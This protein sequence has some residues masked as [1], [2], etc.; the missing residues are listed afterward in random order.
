[1][2][3]SATAQKFRHTSVPRQ[4]GE[5]ARLKVVQGPDAGAIYVV[6]G[7]RATIGRGEDCDVVVSDLKASRS[8]AELNLAGNQWSLKDL[9]SA[10]GVVLNGKS[11][12]AGALKANDVFVV[13]ETTLICVSPGLRGAPNVNA[14]A[15]PRPA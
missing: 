6:N 13:G 11:M 1:M 5:R 10:N 8:H 9:G 14:V 12:R 4:A 3:Q 7:T 2:R 15:G